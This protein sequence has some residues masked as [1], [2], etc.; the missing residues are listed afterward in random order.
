MN[1]LQDSWAE[2]LNKVKD[3]MVDFVA[4]AMRHKLNIHFY[5]SEV[6]TKRF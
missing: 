1:Y 4:D 3:V 5:E 6:K 2:D